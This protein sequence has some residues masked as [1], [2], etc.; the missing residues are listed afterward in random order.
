[1]QNFCISHHLLLE[2]QR[3]LEQKLTTIKKE[4]TDIKRHS[5]SFD[6]DDKTKVK[7]VSR[8]PWKNI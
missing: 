7:R 4:L 3:H 6:Y 1:M 8:Y 2:K 5:N